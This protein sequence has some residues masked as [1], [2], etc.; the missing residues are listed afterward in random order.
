MRKEEK[1]FNNE[2][3]QERVDKPYS[4]EPDLLTNVTIL[5]ERISGD[6]KIKAQTQ[7]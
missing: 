4:S 5:E 7:V 1:Q 2:V 3:E 6:I